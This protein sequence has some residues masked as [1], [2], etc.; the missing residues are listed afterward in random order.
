MNSTKRSF[1]TLLVTLLVFLANVAVSTAA[2]AQKQRTCEFETSKYAAYTVWRQP[3]LLVFSSGMTVDADGSPHAYHPKDKGLDTLRN[4]GRPGNWDA[5]I[6]RN[7]E[8]LR[9]GPNDPAPDFYVSTTSL[10]DYSQPEHSQSR[11][12]DAETVPYIALPSDLAGPGLGDLAVVIDTTSGE[13]SGAILADRSPSGKLG[14]GSIALAKNL[15][16]DPDP[17]YGGTDE[18]IVFVV[19]LDSSN[20]WPV[21]ARRLSE[22]PASMQARVDE[23]LR[24]TIGE[25]STTA[26]VRTAQTAT[27]KSDST[28]ASKLR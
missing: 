10:Q 20:G 16:I 8:P 9:Q 25:K 17:R 24:C 2:W 27:L 3:D 4:A 23:A 15:R 13:R 12:V 21:P 28:S 18:G 26:L 7:G 6:M 22:L 14:E 19:F 11:F 5:L 1:H